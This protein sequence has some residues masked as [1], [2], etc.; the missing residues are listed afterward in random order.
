MRVTA[1][2]EVLISAMV[3]LGRP[4][5]E[6]NDFDCEAERIGRTPFDLTLGG[7]PSD[8]E[9]STLADYMPLVH[10]AFWEDFPLP[11]RQEFLEVL[12]QTVQKSGW[13]ALPTDASLEPDLGAT[14]DFV[15]DVEA[16]LNARA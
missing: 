8:A 9:L 13:D 6:A 12:I 16:N 3:D 1:L 5:T 2:L 7:T 4:A 14:Q 10:E 11:S 15:T